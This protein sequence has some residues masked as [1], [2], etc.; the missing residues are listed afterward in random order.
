MGI[1]RFSIGFSCSVSPTMECVIF[2]TMLFN[3][4]VYYSLYGTFLLITPYGKVD[5]LFFLVTSKYVNFM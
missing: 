5:R 3:D 2:E 4:I 1:S